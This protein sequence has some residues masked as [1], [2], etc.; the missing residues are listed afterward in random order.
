MLVWSK[1][2]LEKWLLPGTETRLLYRFVMNHSNGKWPVCRWFPYSVFKHHGF[3]SY[4]RLA[5]GMPSSHSTERR[6]F[7]ASSSTE[8][9]IALRAPEGFKNRLVR[10]RWPK[11]YC[12][13]QFFWGLTGFWNPFSLRFNP[14]DAGFRIGFVHALGAIRGMKTW[15]RQIV[16]GSWGNP[17]VTL[18][19]DAK[20]S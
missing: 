12:K 7:C 16:G 6:L 4:V 18:L 5:D 8:R 19:V 10:V 17:T 13:Q 20:I 15:W 3:P 1:T 2:V 14:P 11:A 9:S